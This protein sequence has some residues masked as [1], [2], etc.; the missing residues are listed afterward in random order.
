MPRVKFETMPPHARLWVFS[1]DREITDTERQALL[2]EVDE[3]LAT[4]AAHGAPL[5]AARQGD[6]KS[7]V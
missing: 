5:T 2:S 6:R 3:F 4:W 7:V 1:A